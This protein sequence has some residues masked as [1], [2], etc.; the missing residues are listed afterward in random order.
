MVSEL[1]Q[2]LKMRQ[3]QYMLMSQ[4]LRKTN[5][6]N[7]AQKLMSQTLNKIDATN[8]EQNWRHKLCAKLTPQTLPAQNWR[9]KLCTNPGSSLRTLLSDFA[10]VYVTALHNLICPCRYARWR[11][12]V[13]VN[14]W[15]HNVW[16]SWWCHEVCSESFT[17]PLSEDAGVYVWHERKAKCDNRASLQV[18]TSS[19]AC[20][21]T[22][23]HW[24]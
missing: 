8:F 22:A 20:V 2:R 6:T 23:I 16:R 24:W 12:K 10:T 4:T 19:F 17:L 5:V 13:W 7:F 9:H 21:L 11:H 14:R 1:L 15:C 3:M 18:N